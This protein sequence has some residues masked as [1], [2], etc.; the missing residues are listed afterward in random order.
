MYYYNTTTE[1][2]FE[3]IAGDLP[4]NEI[5]SGFKKVKQRPQFGEWQHGLWVVNLERKQEALAD[6]ARDKRD[7]L[8]SEMDTIVSNPLRWSSMLS[9]AQNEWAAYRIALLNVPQQKGFPSV[10]DWPKPPTLV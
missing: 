5:P 9:Q 7:A 2:Y 3:T 8:L 10:I 1:E 4:E 6:E